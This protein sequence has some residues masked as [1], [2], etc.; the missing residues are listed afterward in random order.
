MTHHS[1]STM[2]K[3]FPLSKIARY[4]VML[5]LVLVL[6]SGTARAQSFQDQM[7]V[8]SKAWKAGDFAQAQAAYARIIKSF[9]ARAPMLYGPR[10]GLM[11]YKKGLAELRLA[12][13]A[14]RRNNKAEAEKWFGEAA[15]SFEACYTKYP[16][17]AE[18]MADTPN[19]AHKAS[20]Q[21]WAEAMM[22]KGDYKEA[23][24]LYTKFK[25]EKGKRDKFLP[26]PGG[27]QI[28]LAIC[29]FLMPQPDVAAG[30][31]H[32]ETALN[33]KVK[34]H[35]PDNSIV[36]GFLAL[37]Q[38][39]IKDKNENAIVD[40]LNKNRASLTLDPYQMYEFTPVFMKLGANALAAKMYKAAA[41]LYALIPSSEE[42]IE[43]IKARKSQLGDSKGVK[44]GNKIISKARLEEGLA[45]MQAQQL[46]GDP[47]EVG[48][49]S[50]LSYIHGRI[51]NQRGVYGA[52]L[53]LET[54]Y[55]KSKN[56][57]K[58]LYNLIATCATLGDLKGVEHYGNLFVKTFPESKK[59]K[60]VQRLMVSN[61]FFTGQYE[62]SLEIA[63]SMIDE[64]DEGTDQHDL[65]LFVLA[66]SHFYL[67][68]YEEAKDYLAQH[69]KLYP[70]SKFAQHA[71]YFQASNLSRLH[72]WSGAAKLL[73]AFI[74]K[75]PDKESNPYLAH[76]LYDR[77]NCSFSEGEHDSALKIIERMEEDF[78]DSSMMDAAYSMKGKILEGKGK[79]DEAEKA[80]KQAVLI[81]EKKNH[82]L[83]ASEAISNIVG[84]LTAPK[85]KKANPRLKEAVS[86]YDKFMKNYPD[87]PYKP[88]VV[89]FGMPAMKAVGRSKEALKNLQDLITQLAG[90]P[91]QRFLDESINA[92]SQ[93]FL[94]EEGNTPEKLK[95]L[96]YNFPGVDITNKKT[97]ALL[98]I[99]VIGVYEDQIAKAT[100]EKKDDLVL[101]YKA[102]IK[103]L[104]KDLKNT[105]DPKELTNS[106]LLRIGDYLR[107]KTSAPRQ[108]LPYYEELLSRK[109]KEGEYK[110][111]LGIADVMGLSDN[112]ADQKQAITRLEEVLDKTKDDDVVQ[113]KA[114]FRLIEL[115]SKLGNW[116]AVE[117]WAR[118]YL[119][120][121]YSRRTAD[122]S[123]LFAYSFDKRKKFNDAL[124]YYGMVFSRYRGYI[125]ISAPAVKRILEIMWDR[126]LNAGDTV[127]TGKKKI[128]LK[129]ADRQAAYQ[130]IGWPYIS[131]TRR[132]R[133]ENKKI[134]EAEKKAWDEVAALVKEYEASGQIKTMDKVRAEAQ[135]K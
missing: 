26:T 135:E 77:A 40:F 87:S 81:A 104:F 62:K 65:C 58:H 20:L 57:E 124:F 115:N 28:N 80:Y 36:A 50:A 5:S 19:P 49:L 4:L 127:G 71:A 6:S 121:K 34:M 83:T 85:G 126:N 64:L 117:K 3:L 12:S 98:R 70:K 8:A 99:A 7:L 18:G 16:P 92:F 72:D 32:F 123:Y 29:N 113:E 131:S 44:D 53:Q 90:D 66:G 103:S 11:W 48:V 91:K 73:D 54:F 45:K 60:D 56:R 128:T 82:K 109:D 47:V 114:I 25:K 132:I 112:P 23:L 51:G 38:A 96:Y 100:A 43:D 46:S 27:F 75:Y 130:L 21:R 33:N 108:A 88:Q 55:K 97:L 106:V 133:E 94:E 107:E 35:T 22:G 118:K 42:V 105:F 24:R 84:M 30:I 93:Y 102:G 122:V 125:R 69:V 67:G 95:E 2:N 74:S 79:L 52:L 119:D 78:S 86:W 41:G 120:A 68:Q 15:A 111:L 89:V 76:A 110:A 101:R 134:T 9:E 13:A 39:V 1:P 17:K 129:M 59:A 63:K 37:S 61:L 14:K 31:R 10:F 116:E